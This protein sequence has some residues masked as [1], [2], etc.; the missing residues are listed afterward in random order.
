MNTRNRTLIQAAFLA[1]LLLGSATDTCRAVCPY[2]LFI[3]NSASDNA[4]SKFGNPCRL[5]GG[6]R[7]IGARTAEVERLLTYDRATSSIFHL[8]Y[9]NEA[10][11]GWTLASAEAGLFLPYGPLEIGRST[12]DRGAV[13]L[14]PPPKTH[15]VDT[16]GW[17]IEANQSPE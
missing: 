6:A 5:P 13:W 2:P 3:C 4:G 14:T 15:V 10:S 7:V 12:C 17:L 8:D 11:R 1:F 9:T 16:G